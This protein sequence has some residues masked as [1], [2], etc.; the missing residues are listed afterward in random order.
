MGDRT[1]VELTVLK[2]HLE[3]TKEL[4]NESFDDE[5]IAQNDVLATITFREV[6][7]GELD[8]L[9]TLLAEGIAYDSY[10]WNGREYTWGTEYGRFLEDGTTI[11]KTIYDDDDQSMPMDKLLE[12]IDDY[13]AL[14]AAIRKREEELTVLPFDN[15]EARGKLY[16]IKKL[17]DSIHT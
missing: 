17:I 14:K 1:T 8:V 12:V 10:W 9:P 5:D 7:Y 4:V 6:N 2:V 15:Q 13:E 11:V 16:L 3:K